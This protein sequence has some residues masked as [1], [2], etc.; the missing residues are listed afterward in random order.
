MKAGT[1]LSG[2]TAA[3]SPG[4]NPY[5]RRWF[6]REFAAFSLIELVIV[7][8]LILILTTL[9]W[10]SGSGD[11]QKAL[12]TSCQNHLQKIHTAMEILRMT[13]PESFQQRRARKRQR[14]RSMR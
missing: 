8:A 11:R 5:S 12:L 4:L 1:R 3:D 9:Y 14:N 2:W 13:M 6:R 10:R 7:V